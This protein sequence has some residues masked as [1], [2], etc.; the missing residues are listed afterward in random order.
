MHESQPRLLHRP[1]ELGETAKQLRVKEVK[2]AS[3]LEV[4]REAKKVRQNGG[5]A[6][7]AGRGGVGQEVQMRAKSERHREGGGG[8][9]KRRDAEIEGGQHVVAA[10]LAE[11]EELPEPYSTTT[12]QVSGWVIPLKADRAPAGRIGLK[13]RRIAE[14]GASPELA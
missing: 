1:P 8:E 5:C 13:A 7:W 3:W 11:V 2:R 10:A 9:R 14:P 12:T 4:C 6:H